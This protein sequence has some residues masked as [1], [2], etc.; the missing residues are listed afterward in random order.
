MARILRLVFIRV[1][2]AA[3]FLKYIFAGN[4]F[5]EPALTPQAVSLKNE[6]EAHHIGLRLAYQISF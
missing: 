4:Y 6:G 2:C 5:Y 3:I 1:P